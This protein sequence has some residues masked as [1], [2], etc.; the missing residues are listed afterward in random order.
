MRVNFYILADVD[1]IAR[2][3]F[4]CRLAG[5][6]VAAGTRVH[7]RAPAA[8][9]EEIDALLWEYPP[10]RFLPHVRLTA[11]GAEGGMQ[12]FRVHA[13][14]TTALPGPVAKGLSHTLTAPIV[15]AAEDETPLHREM[16]I[17]LAPD[18]PDFL[19]GFE[20]V[21]EIILAGER[22]AGRTK[23]RSYRERGYPLFHHE[24]D[25]WE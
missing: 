22:T 25:D 20:R 4:T 3:R 1:E 24:L 18:I 8:A 21:S 7:V 10:D 23:Y 13:G 19:A 12:A 14:E 15:V 2:Q 17:N 5:R 11:A 16:L 9:V 6:A